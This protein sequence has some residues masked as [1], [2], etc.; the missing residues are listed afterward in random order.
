[1][2]TLT[3]PRER[4]TILLTKGALRR[5]CSLIVNGHSEFQNPSG[6]QRWCWTRHEGG[7]RGQEVLVECDGLLGERG[8]LVNLL[9]EHLRSDL[10]VGT[11]VLDDSGWECDD[12]ATGAE[13]RLEG[14]VGTAEDLFGGVGSGVQQLPETVL[15]R[16]LSRW[17]SQLV[18]RGRRILIRRESES[19]ESKG[20]VGEVG[21]AGEVVEELVPTIVPVS[22]LGVV[23]EYANERE[24][25]APAKARATIVDVGLVEVDRLVV[26]ATVHL[27]RQHIL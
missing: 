18:T 27:S 2:D 9:R 3:L 19:K 24:A 8:G 13:F 23:A 12:D 25:E 21:A 5:R 16:Y 6:R 11:L 4:R 7:I 14:V 20:A 22:T 10:G 26:P 17:S 15:D 1:M